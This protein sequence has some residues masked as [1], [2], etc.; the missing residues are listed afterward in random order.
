MTTQYAARYGSIVPTSIATA[1][2]ASPM[3]GSTDERVRTTPV[4]TASASI[5]S[6]RS[7]H[8]ESL[9][10][11]GGDDGAP[12]PAVSAPAPAP[13][14]GLAPTASGRPASDG[15][16]SDC[17]ALR[18]ARLL[19]NRKL[20]AKSAMPRRSCTIAA[21]RVSSASPNRSRNAP[22][23]SSTTIPTAR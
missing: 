16:A 10:G 8:R 15:A 2:R 12:G 17:A 14:H 20:S 7:R 19:S 4:P 23:P 1:P 13:V 18:A 6:A 11:R 5:P 3:S 21:A 22:A 9:P